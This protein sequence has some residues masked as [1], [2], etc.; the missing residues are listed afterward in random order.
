MSVIRTLKVKNSDGAFGDAVPL[1]SKT[2]YILKDDGTPLEKNGSLN[3]APAEIGA[4][5]KDEVD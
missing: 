5:T 2:K 3:I 1:G 4:Y